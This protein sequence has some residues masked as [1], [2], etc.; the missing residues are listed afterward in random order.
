M[1]YLQKQLVP[2]EVISTVLIV[3]KQNNVEYTFNIHW[4]FEKQKNNKYCIKMFH[5]SYPDKIMSFKKRSELYFQLAILHRLLKESQQHFPQ[6][7]IT[8]FIQAV[9]VTMPAVHIDLIR[10]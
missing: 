8:E 1:K 2:N 10:N 7:H 3:N 9:F 6:C 4:L 5:S